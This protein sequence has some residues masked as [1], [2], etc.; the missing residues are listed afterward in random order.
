MVEKISGL[1]IS[2]VL[3]LIIKL[4]TLLQLLVQWYS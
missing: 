1:P 4:Q 2:A 3:E